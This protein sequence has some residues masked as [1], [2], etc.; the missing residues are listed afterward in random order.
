MPVWVRPAESTTRDCHSPARYSSC[1]WPIVTTSPAPEHAP[2][3]DSVPVH[4][5]PVGRAQVLDHVPVLAVGEPG[6]AAG[7]IPI[8]PEWDI[9]GFVTSGDEVA[10]EVDLGSLGQ[11]G[12]R[13]HQEPR[14]PP[15]SRLERRRP[16]GRRQHHALLADRDVARGDADHPPDEQVEEDD[17]R[18]LEREQELLNQCGART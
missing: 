11:L 9:E 12:A 10:P 2:A 8:G 3:R 6:M 14:P 13:D 1:V 5:R 18:D 4:E 17:E 15:G 16:L 7:S